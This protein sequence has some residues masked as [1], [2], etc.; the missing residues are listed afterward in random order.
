MF[1]ARPD[2][3]LPLLPVFGCEFAWGR[4]KRRATKA[5]LL[6]LPG[7]ICQKHS[8]PNEQP[9]KNTP[10]CWRCLGLASGEVFGLKTRLLVPPT[11][12]ARGSKRRPFHCPVVEAEHVPLK[13][14]GNT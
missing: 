8:G 11:A 10:L 2:A 9:E 13:E 12:Q 5:S 3:W 14:H 4:S 1:Y 6:R 7:S